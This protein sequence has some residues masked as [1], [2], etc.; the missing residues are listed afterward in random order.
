MHECPDILVLS[1]AVHTRS[2]TRVQRVSVS[3]LLPRTFE[4]EEGDFGSAMSVLTY[5]TIKGGLSA[6]WL[7]LL[8]RVMRWPLSAFQTSSNPASS[9]WS[10]G[11]ITLV[12]LSGSEAMRDTVWMSFIEIITFLPSVQS[13]DPRVAKSR[14]GPGLMIRW[15][16]AGQGSGARR[17]GQSSPSLFVS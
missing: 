12:K 6:D 5:S 2:W 8:L 16:I 3:F 9:C 15:Y 17:L 4:P 13:R 7:A 10:K 14:S 1:F 11:D